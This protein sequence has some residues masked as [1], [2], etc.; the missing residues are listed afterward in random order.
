MKTIELELYQDPVRYKVLSVNAERYE[1]MVRFNGRLEDLGVVNAEGDAESTEE[2][3]LTEE[4]VRELCA[5]PDWTVHVRA[6]GWGLGAWRSGKR[7]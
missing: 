7:V 1:V 2:W 3:W 6:S 4:V 5:D